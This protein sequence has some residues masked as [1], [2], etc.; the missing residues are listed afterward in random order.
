MLPIIALR[1]AEQS[2]FWGNLWRDVED[3]WGGGE[4]LV[5]SS[6]E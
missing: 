3:A 6:E 5:V 1:F 2:P 4:E